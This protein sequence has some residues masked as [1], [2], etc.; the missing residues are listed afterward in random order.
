MHGTIPRIY[1]HNRKRIRLEMNI[2]FSNGICGETRD[3]FTR[4]Y[5]NDIRA[6]QG[7]PELIGRVGSLFIA[8]WSFKE[9]GEKVKGIHNAQSSCRALAVFSV[10]LIVAALAVANLIAAALLATAACFLVGILKYK[11][12]PK[13]KSLLSEYGQQCVIKAQ[14]A[15]GKGWLIVTHNPTDPGIK[16]AV[17][18][19]AA[20]FS[21]PAAYQ[22][23]ADYVVRHYQ[24]ISQPMTVNPL[25][26]D[27]YTL[28][29]EIFDRF[30]DHLLKGASEEQKATAARHFV[31]P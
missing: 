6:T 3:R 10:A 15:I 2:L 23:H 27:Y 8:Q 9:F 25:V 31:S 1:T 17:E 18:K 7:H 13:C 5:E 22:E 14:N 30:I 28:A 21:D 29:K 24:S 26:R 12:I 19:H 20:I 4:D 16:A 11:E